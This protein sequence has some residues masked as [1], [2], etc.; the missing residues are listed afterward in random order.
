VPVK[1]T[2]V[3]LYLVRSGATE[4]SLASMRADFPRIARQLAERRIETLPN[5][6]SRKGRDA[7]ADDLAS[8]FGLQASPVRNPSKEHELRNV[9]PELRPYKS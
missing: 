9:L 5:P 1:P 7:R 2:D 3:E 4:P 8:L 6:L